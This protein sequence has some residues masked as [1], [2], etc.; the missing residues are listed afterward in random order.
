MCNGL[1]RDEI[2]ALINRRQRQI[3]VHSIIY[4]KMSENII[5]DHQWSEWAEELEQLQKDYPD[6]ALTQKYGEA[7]KG[8]D[9]STG[10]NLPLYDE[11]AVRVARRLLRIMN[12]EE[13]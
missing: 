2:T 10:M 6:I 7:F 3:L 13:G 1:T 4:Y 11:D 12:K 8:F 5:D 9:H